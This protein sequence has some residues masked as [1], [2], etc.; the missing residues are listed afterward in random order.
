MSA[1]EQDRAQL[2]RTGKITITSRQ[3]FTKLELCTRFG[4][5][6]RDL[7]KIDSKIAN[8]MP[9]ILV[10]REAILFSVLHLR[11]II[12]ANE[13]TLFDTIGSEDTFLKGV[14]L[15][16]LEHNLKTPTKAAHGLPYEFRALESCLV[17]VV[18]ALEGELTM[19]RG[20]VVDLLDGLEETIQRDRLKLLLQYSRKLST[21][22]KRATLVQECLEELLE[23]GMSLCGSLAVLT[24]RRRRPR[25]NV[26]H[27][28]DCES[29]Q[30]LC[31]DGGARRGGAPAR[32]VRE[33][34]GG[35]RER[36]RY[37]R[38]EHPR[39]SGRRR[40]DSGLESQRATRAGP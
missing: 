22:Q 32:V 12:T 35:D 38:V 34:N 2:I 26:P 33:A 24:P 9:V 16:S 6:P 30:P 28:S 37:A 17:S 21:F 1:L 19:L 15:Y 25:G 8:V 20:L 13:V 10:R 5:Q 36:G 7:R 3:L 27:A 14:F 23:A 29:W 4:L 11:V 31:R 18:S 40:A 39:D